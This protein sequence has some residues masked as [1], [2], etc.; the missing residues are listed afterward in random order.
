MQNLHVRTHMH[1]SKIHVQ[2][3]QLEDKTTSLRLE[4]TLS[5]WQSQAHFG[6]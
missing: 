1:V 2:P 5:D 6:F 3:F 4:A